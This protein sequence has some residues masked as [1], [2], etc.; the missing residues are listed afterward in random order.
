MAKSGQ[1]ANLDVKD[2]LA[3]IADGA[4]VKDLAQEYGVTRQAIQYH[5]RDLPEYK[6]AKKVSYAV[7]LDDINGQMA[8]LG[9]GPPPERPIRP[10]GELSDLQKTAHA[11][12]M[13][14]YHAKLT[15]WKS[16]L[17]GKEFTLAV[18]ERR[19]RVVAWLAEREC[20]A[21][22]GSKTH[23]HVTGEITL[24][25]LLESTEGVT[26]EAEAVTVSPAA[27]APPLE[28][29]QYIPDAPRPQAR[30]ASDGPLTSFDALDYRNRVDR[31]D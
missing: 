2:V 22:W 4:F 30:P 8:A 6:V 24:D 26:I 5:L 10:P 28:D 18:L 29:A 23:L 9:A 21:E 19:H 27:D 7:Q 14:E 1:L 11:A 20:P 15:D 25:M 12:A 17:T 13:D 3:K 16:R 31:H